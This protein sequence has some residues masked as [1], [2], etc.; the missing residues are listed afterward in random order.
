MQYA[1]MLELIDAAERAGENQTE[2]VNEKLA[3]AF[4]F[5]L[6]EQHFSY[7]GT[8]EEEEEALREAFEKGFGICFHRH[9]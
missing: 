4:E 6:E 1:K 9:A 7:G 2:F 5:W 3:D 8:T